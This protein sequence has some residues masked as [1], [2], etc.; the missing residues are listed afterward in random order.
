VGGSVPLDA[1]DARLDAG[2]PPLALLD[3]VVPTV[4]TEEIPSE[5][6]LSVDA[7]VGGEL[8]KLDRVVAMSVDAAGVAVSVATISEDDKP[9]S[10]E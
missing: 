1:D 4:L 10:V 3:D 5:A 2:E 8:D 9:V 6:A 7:E